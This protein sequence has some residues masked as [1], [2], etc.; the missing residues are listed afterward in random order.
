MKVDLTR[1]G[2]ELPD[3]SQAV[4]AGQAEKPASVASGTA[5]ADQAQFSFDQAR[6]HSLQAQVL[7]QPEIRQAKVRALQQAIGKDEYSVPAS[8]VAGALIND[9][10]ADLSADLNGATG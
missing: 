1:V 6:V 8:H 9:L 7:A 5:G 3:Q 10:S 2:L 4:R